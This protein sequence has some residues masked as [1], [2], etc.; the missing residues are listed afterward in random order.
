MRVGPWLDFGCHV[1][2]LRGR[3]GAGYDCNLDNS[4]FVL[5]AINFIHENPLCR[6]L[7]SSMMKLECIQF[8]STRN[9]DAGARERLPAHLRKELI[10]GT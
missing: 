7:R 10:E 3:V 1:P 5:A 2:R 9:D 6:N 8:W 4:Q